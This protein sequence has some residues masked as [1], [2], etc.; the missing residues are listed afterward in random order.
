MFHRRGVHFGVSAGA[1]GLIA[2]CIDDRSKSNTA[3]AVHGQHGI[4]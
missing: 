4:F 1:A 3:S 2:S